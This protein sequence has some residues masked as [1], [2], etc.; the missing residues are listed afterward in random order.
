MNNL[1]KYTLRD[2]GSTPRTLSQDAVR[3]TL[4]SQQCLVPCGCCS[5]NKPARD[6]QAR[7]GRSVFLRSRDPLHALAQR[8]PE[9]I[10]NIRSV[11]QLAA[12]HDRGVCGPSTSTIFSIRQL[13]IDVLLTLL[14]LRSYQRVRKLP[15]PQIPLHSR[16]QLSLCWLVHSYE[17]YRT[18]KIPISAIPERP[19]Q[20]T[21]DFQRT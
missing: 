8:I 15:S 7:F 6:F 2:Q 13:V 3:R 9:A 1:R 17:T 5:E 18:Q 4:T 14:T 11:S 21:M 16:Y 19:V 20:T 10:G 12:R